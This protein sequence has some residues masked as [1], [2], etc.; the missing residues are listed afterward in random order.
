[1]KIA[2]AV[3]ACLLAAAPALAAPTQGKVC[4]DPH[5]DYQT[6]ALSEHDVVA[7][8]TFGHDHRPIKISTTCI[9]LKRADYIRLWTQFKCVDMGDHVFATQIGVQHESCRVTHVEPFAPSAQQG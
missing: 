4:L 3:F 9:N 5:W 6:T 8:Q 2:Y 7:H 1:M